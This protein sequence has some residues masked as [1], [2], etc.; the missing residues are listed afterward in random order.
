MLWSWPYAN[1]VHVD[2]K[3]V[4]AGRTLGALALIGAVSVVAIGVSRPLPDP[5]LMA[6]LD[7]S[8]LQ[9]SQ[10]NGAV[11]GDISLVTLDESFAP[12]PGGE[13]LQG[14]FLVRNRCSESALLQVY[15]GAWDVT[16]GASGIWRADLNGTAG[17]PVTLTGPSRQE[18]WGVLISE[19]SA[20]ANQVIPVKLY[21]GIPAAETTQGY[22]INPAWAFSLEQVEPATVPDAPSGLQVQPGSPTTAD[23]VTVT[24]TAEP[25][26]TVD[27]TVDGQIRCTTTADQDGSFSCVVGTLSSGK[28]QVSATATN[29]VGTSAAADPVTVTVRSAGPTGWGSLDDLFNW[30]SLGGLGSLGSVGS[31]DSGG[32]AAGSAVGSAAG[33]TTG[34]IAAGSLGTLGSAATGSG[35]AGPGAAEPGDAGPG[36]ANTAGSGA[37]TAGGSGPGAPGAPG[38]G[39]TAQAG[40][41]AATAPGSGQGG[42]AT[43]T[44]D[45]SPTGAGAGQGPLAGGPDGTSGAGGATG[46]PGPGGPGQSGPGGGAAGAGT[47]GGQTPGAGTGAATGGQTAGGSPAGELSAGSL[48]LGSSAPGQSVTRPLGSVD[49]LIQLGSS[50]IR[51]E[52]G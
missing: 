15:A 47:A 42:G 14:D 11:W 9:F 39:G 13:Y 26:S 35:A 6:N 34:S 40:A 19:T 48:G 5:H 20:P 28:H 17:A 10:D 38:A 31:S 23:R 45:G 50:S 21:L 43:G 44:G 29:T 25:G 24:G 49:G 7:N 4:G 46:A 37:V 30:G 52:Q 2:G 27:V 22:S 3:L 1:G 36:G 32:S 8:C 51:V 18:D 33:S 12:V 41:G 16:D